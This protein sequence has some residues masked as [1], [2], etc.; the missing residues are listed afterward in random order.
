MHPALQNHDIL[1]EIFQKLNYLVD[2]P[3]AA[4]TSKAALSRTLVAASRTCKV[5]AD[6]ALDV[7]WFKLESL[8]PLL[9][10]IGAFIPS[11]A[12]V[13]WLPSDG[14]IA[15]VEWERFRKY[16]ARIHILSLRRD[17]RINHRVLAYLS[18]KNDGAPLLPALQELSW[19][20]QDV[21]APDLV[22]WLPRSLHT[23]TLENC[24]DGPDEGPYT[25]AYFDARVQLLQSAWKQIIEKSPYVRDVHLISFP[26]R[27]LGPLTS[28]KHIKRVHIQDF[29]YIYKMPRLVCDRD[30]I[31]YLSRIEGFT[32]LK[33]EPH[34]IT[35]PTF[36]GFGSLC[37]LD[38]QGPL[39][40]LGLMTSVVSSSHLASLS[41]WHDADEQLQD[42]L[43]PSNVSKFSALSSFQ[44]S[45]FL[46]EDHV[47][48][49]ST[50][51]ADHLRPLL[52]L[53]ALEEVTIRVYLGPTVKFAL[54]DSDIHD[55]A[56]SWRRIRELYLMYTADDRSP[57]IQSLRYFVELCPDLHSLHLPR[58]NGATALL[59][60]DSYPF[61]QQTHG[62]KDLTLR[63]V[64]WSNR[65][66]EYIDSCFPSLEIPPVPGPFGPQETKEWREIQDLVSGLQAE[67]STQSFGSGNITT[68]TDLERSEH[69]NT[70]GWIVIISADYGEIH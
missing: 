67:R 37:D 70:H 69:N 55:L 11:A 49:Q 24:D 63:E 33:I 52:G 27:I 8:Q 59:E 39:H 17:E 48:A 47:I 6:F 29:H 14:M 20:L 15:P 57:S 28:M 4:W 51:L 13:L 21:I 23:L 46:G 54:S 58:I 19:V 7:L 2:G 56:K 25:Q 66:A 34:F 22:T 44:L 31:Q 41:I 38:I 60:S 65:I 3:D 12:D 32:V 68:E 30:L 26:R 16:A 10:I 35:A 64:P 18:A 36:S 40:Q 42:G 5:F 45:V 9:N 62:L 43:L 53:R 1:H 61:S 50:E